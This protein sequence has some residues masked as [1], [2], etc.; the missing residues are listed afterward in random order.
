MD[1]D[2]V[3]HEE[4][5]PGADHRVLRSFGSIELLGEPAKNSRSKRSDIASFMA[6]KIFTSLFSL[7][8][9]SCEGSRNWRIS[10]PFII[11]QAFKAFESRPNCSRVSSRSRFSILPFIRLYRTHAFHYAIPYEYYEKYRIRRYGFHGTSHHFVT[12]QAAKLIGKPIEETQFISAHLGNGCSAAAI[13]HGQSID[14]TMGLTPLE[15]LVMG[16]RS[17]DVDPSL[18]FFLQEKE[19][20]SLQD[21]TRKS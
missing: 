12:L 7:P 19:E 15:G 2:G 3:N 5:I 14:T 8:K 16:T 4:A 20:R 11:R 1:L 13:R 21:I 9:A 18:H 17:G 10:H 6:E